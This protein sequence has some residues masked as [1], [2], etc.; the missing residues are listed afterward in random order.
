MI[1]FTLFAALLSTSMNDSRAVSS[2]TTANGSI[3][4]VLSR[5]ESPASETAISHYRFQAAVSRSSWTLRAQGL[6]L[7]A[8]IIG[9][10]RGDP[11]NLQDN[12]N[13]L[14]RRR[15]HLLPSCSP[16]HLAINHAI[17]YINKDK[18]RTTSAFLLIMQPII[19]CRTFT[20]RNVAV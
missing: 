5:S 20:Q 3:C 19:T 7:E 4:A 18:S 1:L 17:F 11:S 16:L 8:S 12:V 6:R 2:Y 9:W 10:H 13:K 14:L 15:S